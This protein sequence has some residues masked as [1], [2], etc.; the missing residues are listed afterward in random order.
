MASQWIAN[1]LV[2]GTFPLLL[3]NDTLNAAWNSR[4]RRSG[5]TAASASIAAFIV[6][7][8]VPET[9]GV[10]S[11]QL[12]WR[13]WRSEDRGRGPVSAASADP[14]H[15][16]AEFASSA[17]SRVACSSGGRLRLGRARLGQGLRQRAASPACMR[18]LLTRDSFSS[19][20][21]SRPFGPLRSCVP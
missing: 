21:G 4:L 5:C 16:A 8:Y 7:R 10:D 15:C 11:D 1:L 17:A 3:G 2:S 13:L 9:R 6:L 18:M 12:S 20:W 19:G 14:P